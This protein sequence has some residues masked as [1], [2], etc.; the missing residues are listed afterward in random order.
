MYI[1]SEALYYDL[2]INKVG[3]AAGKNLI[4]YAHEKKVNIVSPTSFQAYLTIILLGLHQIKINK[5]TE[6]I[7]KN[8]SQ[9]KKH[10]SNYEIFL[11]KL[12]NHLNTALSTY[13]KTYDEFQKIDKDIYKL[14][15]ENELNLLNQGEENIKKNKF[16]EINEN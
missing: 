5:S 1:P 7:R 4:E 15:G 2:L 3:G 6:K 13:N 10:L 12:G 14:T 16:L 9:L 8:L 11:K